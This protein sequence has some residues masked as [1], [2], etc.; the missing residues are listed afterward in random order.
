MK[1]GIIMEIGDEFLTLLTPDGEFLR[2]RKQNSSYSIGEEIVFTPLLKGNR[3]Y[4]YLFKQLF[5]RKPLPV[6]LTA[7]MLFLISFISLNQ[8]NK[9]Y[10]YMSIDVNPSMELGL[11]NQMRVIKLTA[12]NHDGEK[13]ISH[14]TK[15]KNQEASQVTK[16]LLNEMK[17]EGFFEKHH[18]VVISTVRTEQKDVSA[19]KI[20]A[21]NLNEIKNEVKQDHLN[22]TLL[23]GTKKQMKNAHHEGLTTGKYQEINMQLLN[24]IQQSK[25]SQS[26]QN[27]QNKVPNKVQDNSTIQNKNTTLPKGI[28]K[29]KQE[30]NKK[31][32]EKKSVTHHSM[33][34]RDTKKNIHKPELENEEEHDHKIRLNQIIN[35]RNTESKLNAEQKDKTENDEHIKENDNEGNHGS[36]SN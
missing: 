25:P 28:E 26:L 24:K 21:R 34:N 16:S 18:L 2:T 12:F 17:K 22:L 36:D 23:S 10:A 29:P 7:M 20:L 14:I 32:I 19:E 6:I 35:D 30:V 33:M 5:I 9:A 31:E 4:F 13:I 11:N 8:N 15:W 3:N 1:K 27:E